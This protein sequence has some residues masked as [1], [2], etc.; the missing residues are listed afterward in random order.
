MGCVFEGGEQFPM[1]RTEL[2]TLTDPAGGPAEQLLT[3]QHDGGQLLKIRTELLAALPM[4]ITEENDNINGIDWEADGDPVVL[5]EG[6]ARLTEPDGTVGYGMFE[7][8]ARRSA[9]TRP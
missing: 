7:R 8:G 2:A 6:I 5:V 4:T 9:L 1:A 3:V